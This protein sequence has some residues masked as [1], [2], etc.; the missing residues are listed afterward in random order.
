MKVNDTTYPLDTKSA[1]AALPKYLHRFD[2]NLDCTRR[3]HSDSITHFLSFAQ[4]DCASSQGQA[5]ITESDLLKWMKRL[6]NEFWKDRTVNTLRSVNR[7]LNVLVHDGVVVTNP[8]A[9]TVE[10]YRKHRWLGIAAAL[11]SKTPGRALESLRVVSPFQG[12]IGQL[13]EAY[14]TL[15]HCGGTKCQYME[16]ALTNFNRFLNRKGI[17]SARAVTSATIYAW[18]QSLSLS[19]NTRRARALALRLFFDYLTSLGVVTANPVVPEILDNIGPHQ[20]VFR[21]H[22]Y[23]PEEVVALLQEAERIPRTTSF[24]LKPETFHT[25][26]SLLYTLGL[27]TGEALRLRLEDIDLE[28]NTLLIRN[29]K[30]YKDRLIPFGPKMGKRLTEFLRLRKTVLRPVHPSDP[31]F[32]SRRRE[33]VSQVIVNKVF[34]R[35]LDS[36][37]IV[38][39]TGQKR[40][41]LYDLRHAFAVN[42]LLQW[43]KEGMDVQSRLVHLST[44]MGHDSVESTQVYLTIT[45]ELLSEANKRFYAECGRQLEDPY[46]GGTTS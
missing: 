2:A 10:R 4:K 35:I 9:S 5:L 13:S 33:S 45:H 6:A 1:E 17:T 32:V 8:L 7:F 18:C 36:A 37:G 43:Y 24:S 29:T 20:R 15:K 14:L 11:Y 46:K 3:R 44:F 12:N 39:E 31:L 28:R 23:T 26:V 40:P 41:R 19:Q 22:I 34:N 16:R 25:I 38:V 27:R 21:P 30:F 42:R